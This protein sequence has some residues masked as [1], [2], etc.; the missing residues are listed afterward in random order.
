MIFTPLSLHGAYIVEPEV[1]QD[2]RGSF[3]RFFCTDEFRQI[4]HD[5]PWVQLNHSFTKSKGTVRGLHF[6]LPPHAEIKMVKCIA[7]K[8]LDVIIDL[9]KGSSTFLQWTGVEIS[10]ENRRMMYIPEGFA[11]GFQTLTDD[12]EMIY[13][14]SEV[15]T[16]DAEGGIRWN[17]PLINIKW[18]LPAFHIS[19]RDQ[20]FPLITNQFQ[21]IKV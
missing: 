7:G 19:T 10:A 1:F 3:Y 12:C 8:I 21:G 11:H 18:P 17:D 6:Q 13:H 15:Y 16:K 9:R 5:K 14:H 20:Q 2:E 4:G